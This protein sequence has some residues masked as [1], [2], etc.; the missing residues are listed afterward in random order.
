MTLLRPTVKRMGPLAHGAQQLPE[1]PQREAR[2]AEVGR[3]RRRAAL[4]GRVVA[5][6]LFVVVIGMAVT[7][8][9]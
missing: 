7:R 4:T 2:M 9:M 8:Y 6:L 3:L 5:G 1:G